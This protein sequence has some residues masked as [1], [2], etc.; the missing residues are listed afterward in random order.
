MIST[1]AL[2]LVLLLILASLNNS[3]SCLRRGY[4]SSLLLTG[5]FALHQHS[6]NASRC[7]LLPILPMLSEERSIVF[8]P[9]HVNHQWDSPH[10][11]ITQSY[12]VPFEN[13]SDKRPFWS[14]SL[15]CGDYLWSFDS[16]IICPRGL[17]KKSY[18]P[19]WTN[20]AFP[21][22][23]CSS[24]REPLG[25]SLLFQWNGHEWH[26]SPFQKMTCW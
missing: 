2:F 9:F 17:T 20:I 12:I 8:N 25:F 5:Y 24:V 4:F 10:N 6:I 21:W 19:F 16:E 15:E 11:F 23:V 13:K 22:A 18:S 3:S 26:F 1:C 7:L 14:M